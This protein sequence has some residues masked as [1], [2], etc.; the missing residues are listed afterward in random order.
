MG[1]EMTTE[2]TDQPTKVTGAP[3]IWLSPE[4]AERKLPAWVGSRPGDVRYLRADLVEWQPIA[5]APRDGTVVDLWA[6]GGHRSASQR[7]SRG[8]NWWYPSG[9]NDGTVS[10]WRP[11]AGPR[12][13]EES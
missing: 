8:G 1:A 13:E 6:N 7:W 11:I 9:F 4:D 12:N 2:P 5:T 10:H 3:E